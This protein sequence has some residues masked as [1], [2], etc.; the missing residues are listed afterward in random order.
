M[1]GAFEVVVAHLALDHPGEG[2]QSAWGPL[3]G[4]DL[5]DGQPDGDGEP[6]RGKRTA[7]VMV[8]RRTI[9][10]VAVND[11]RSGSSSWSTALSCIRARR[12]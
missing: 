6:V 5:G 7:R 10:S 12:A 1:V 2:S 8:W 11:S 3:F 9:R 4:E